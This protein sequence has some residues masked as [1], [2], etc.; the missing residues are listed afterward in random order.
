M[1]SLSLRINLD[2]DGKIGPGKIELLE[3]IAA[4]GSISAGA[5][6]MKMSYKHAWDLVEEMNRLFG[7]P[8]VAAQTGGKR[9]GGAQL[10]PV[11][12][13]VVSRFRAIERAA[14][15]AAEQHIVA[16]QKEIAIA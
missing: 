3:H 10:T 6:I 7:K 14:T 11:G 13:A 1:A 5:R 8:V 2:P 4:F 15:A 12:L 16:L 9:G